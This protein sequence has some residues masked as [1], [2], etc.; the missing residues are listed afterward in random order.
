MTSQV[1]RAK[2][3][4][5]VEAAAALSAQLDGAEQLPPGADAVAATKA[6]KKGL[7]TGAFVV[8]QVCAEFTYR[9]SK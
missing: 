3:R 2:A 5:C 6:L 7:Q 4:E 9:L 8:G 1:T